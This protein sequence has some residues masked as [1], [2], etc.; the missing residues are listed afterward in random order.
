[1][2]AAPR[3]ERLKSSREANLQKGRVAR[4]MFMY[5]LLCP[6]VVDAFGCRCCLCCSFARLVFNTHV[7][8]AYSADVVLEVLSALRFAKACAVSH[9]CRCFDW[10]KSFLLTGCELITSWPN[11]DEVGV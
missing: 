5:L 9:A 3:G 10:F 6:R 2:L 8:D 11:H 7:L 1:M 4:R